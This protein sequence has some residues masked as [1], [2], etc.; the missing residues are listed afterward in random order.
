MAKPNLIATAKRLF[1]RMVTEFSHN[2]GIGSMTC[3]IYD[4]AWVSTVAKSNSTSTFWLFPEC[5]NYILD[6]QNDDGGWESYA[7]EVDGILNTAA[8]LYAIKKHATSPIQSLEIYPLELEDR[9]E[10][11][12]KALQSSLDVWDVA[13]SVNVG[14]E[15]LVP[16]ML[17]LLKN[18]GLCFDF[19][20]ITLL[21]KLNN[22]KLSKFNPASLY[23]DVKLTSLHS[24][25]AFIGKLDFDKITHHKTFG[26]L[27]ASPSSTAA[28]LMN[29]KSWD[30]EAE[31]YLS[32]VFAISEGGPNGGIP[33]AYPSKYFEIAWVGSGP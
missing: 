27:M 4:T 16:A 9:I 25:E 24:L 5:F 31:S 28:Y 13:A 6:T 3:S 30:D 14:F 2:N 21:Q 1:D 29:R 32:R 7:T 8:S 20:G 10:R 26:S 15:I 18:Q 22:Q 33:S 12:S 23:G 19:P 17:E 11:A